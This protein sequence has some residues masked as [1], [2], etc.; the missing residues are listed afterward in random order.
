MVSR[1]P[2]LRVRVLFR[3]GHLPFLRMRVPFLYRVHHRMKSA[4]NSLYPV[5]Q[6]LDNVFHA[7]IE[8]FEPM[9]K[10]YIVYSC[11]ALTF[12]ALT[13]WIVDSTLSLRPASLSSRTQRG[14]R[15]AARGLGSLDF[16][17]LMLDFIVH[18]TW[19]PDF[20]WILYLHQ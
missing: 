13:N 15:A 8:T 7:S 10:R 12:D 20:S 17:V 1:L 11:F 14:E 3:V 16:I 5:Y 9:H 6:S 4:F 19:I 18:Q 2:L